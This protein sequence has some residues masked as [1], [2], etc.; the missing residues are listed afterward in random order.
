[1]EQRAGL[2]CKSREAG[3]TQTPHMCLCALLSPSLIRVIHLFFP[4]QRDS[5]RVGELGREGGTSK[6]GR[7]K[8]ETILVYL[9]YATESPEPKSVEWKEQVGKE[10]ALGTVLFPSSTATDVTLTLMAEQ[11]AVPAPRAEPSAPL[12]PCQGP[13]TGKRKA[14]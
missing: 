13:C 2:W 4:W 1:M 3:S 5:W 8:K 7:Q 11:R 9:E 12:A 14:G 6:E 10:R